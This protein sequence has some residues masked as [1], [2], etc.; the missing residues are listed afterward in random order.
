MPKLCFED[1]LIR[2]FQLYILFHKIYYAK[3]SQL[4]IITKFLS[5]YQIIL[6]SLPF[7]SNFLISRWESFSTDQAT[8]GLCEAALG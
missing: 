4:R 5:S 7:T 3:L 1:K 6:K 2:R 8:P